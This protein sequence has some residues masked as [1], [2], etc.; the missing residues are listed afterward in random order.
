M[1][2]RVRVLVIDDSAYNRRTIIKILETIPGIEVIGYACD[3]EEGLRKVFDLKPSLVTLDLEMPRMDGF[4]FLRIVMQSRPT[5]VIVVSARSEDENV[6]K[7]LEL[8]AVEFIA[9]PSARLSPELFNIRED[10]VRKVREIARTDMAKVLQRSALENEA[11]PV[12]SERKVPKDKGAGGRQISQVVIGAST[13]G[14]PALQAIFSAIRQPLPVGF[15]ISQHMPPGFTR[16]FADRLNKFCALEIMEAR[17]GDRVL[18]GRVLISPG[19]KNLVFGRRDGEIFVQ[20]EEPSPDQRYVPSVDVMFLSAAEVFG[21]NLLGIVLTGMGNDGARGVE[22]IKRHG[23]QTLAESEETSVV[24]GM[25]KEAIAT[26]H[27]DK[28]LPFH[29]MSTEIVRR[30]KA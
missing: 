16:A 14:P 30:C 11:P 27:V 26:S 22:G 18:P 5:P 1:T 8:G 4:T 28:V 7:A 17:T 2:D 6:F 3:G 20:L 25:P 13:G 24:F 15:A 12:V 10:L 23:G 21:S 9:K 29:Q 19:G